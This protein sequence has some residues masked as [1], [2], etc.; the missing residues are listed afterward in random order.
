MALTQIVKDGLGASLTA[1]SEGGAVTTS[2]QQGLAKAWVNFNGS[3]TLAVR[4]SFNVTS[5]SDDGTGLYSVDFGNAMSDGN[6]AAIGCATYFGN[7]GATALVYAMR[8]TSNVY[9]EHGTSGFALRISDNNADNAVDSGSVELNVTG[10]L[11]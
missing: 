7:D 10:D 6:Y 3:G 4:D 2:V 9:T 1:T 8:T 5:I 11:A